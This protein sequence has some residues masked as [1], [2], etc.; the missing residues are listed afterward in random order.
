MVLHIPLRLS[1]SVYPNPIAVTASLRYRDG[2]FQ[3]LN[4]LAVFV[5][6]VSYD[7]PTIFAASGVTAKKTGKS[8]PQPIVVPAF[9]SL[10]FGMNS[11]QIVVSVK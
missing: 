6:N 9:R 4:L 7:D 3:D 8:S 10:D 11:G 5:Q 1:Q 2:P